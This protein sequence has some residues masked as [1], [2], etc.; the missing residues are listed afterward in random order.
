MMKIMK[1]LHLMFIF[2]SKGMCIGLSDYDDSGLETATC[3]SEFEQGSSIAFKINPFYMYKIEIQPQAIF[4]PLSNIVAES[5]LPDN[6]M[7]NYLLYS[8]IKVNF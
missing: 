8:T 3:A 5:I 1:V 7:F 2:S 4:L 6:G